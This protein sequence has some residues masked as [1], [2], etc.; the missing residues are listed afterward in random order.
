MSEL[1]DSLRAEVLDVTSES[2]LGTLKLRLIRQA[3]PRKWRSS[4]AGVEQ[5]LRD[6]KTLVEAFQ[7]QQA[8]MPGDLRHLFLEALQV[9]SPLELLLDAVQIQREVRANWHDFLRMISYPLCLF[10]F[11]VLFA[12]GLNAAL[13][14]AVDLQFLEDFQFAGSEVAVQRWNDQLQ[15]FVGLAV[16]CVWVVLVML[17]IYYA[18]PHWAWLSV[19]GSLGGV[20]KPLRWLA[21]HEMLHR[22][23]LF[24]SQGLSTV[25]AV[26]AVARSFK[27][28]S[29]AAVAQSVASRV[30]LGVPF[31][32]AMAS[33]MLSDSLIRPVLLLMDEGSGKL[34]NQIDQATQML[35]KIIHERC[36]TLS[37]ILPVFVLL[38]VVTILGALVTTYFLILLAIWPFLV[39]W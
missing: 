19:A 4:F 28:S 36:Q 16:V 20:G 33:S 3:G 17:T 30:H 23:R 13:F 32:K 21:L 29:S 31:G 8:R 26:D 6:G 35:E 37:T 39:M 2:M 5:E 25:Q 1:T 10:V 24:F 27:V 38:M 12:L 22:Y 11:T 15:A 18:G 14:Y 34:E 7:S 9:A